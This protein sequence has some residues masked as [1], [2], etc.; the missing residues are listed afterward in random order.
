[1]GPAILAQVDQGHQHLRS[2]LE[3]V[4]WYCSNGSFAFPGIQP[5]DFG[6]VP[7]GFKR[8]YDGVELIGCDS[9][10]ALE[11]CG[12]FLKLFDGEPGPILLVQTL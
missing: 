7:D 10:G 5:G 9:G 2:H 3:F 4:D 12:S 8:F 1:M 6:F 11:R